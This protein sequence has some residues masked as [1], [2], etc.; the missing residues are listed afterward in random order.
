MQQQGHAAGSGE[1]SHIVR[2]ARDRCRRRA[3]QPHAKDIYYLYYN[4]RLSTSLNTPVHQALEL[5]Q[6]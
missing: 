6:A 3:T 4:S 1:L 5:L 2:D